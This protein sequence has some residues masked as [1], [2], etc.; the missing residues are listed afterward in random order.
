[1]NAVDADAE[2]IAVG[3]VVRAGFLGRPKFVVR[4]N[5][6]GKLDGAVWIVVW[7]QAPQERFNL[8]ISSVLLIDRY[9]LSTY[10]Q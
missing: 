1:M 8:A 2:L 4:K 5:P 10:K 9:C 6:E 7:V 3:V